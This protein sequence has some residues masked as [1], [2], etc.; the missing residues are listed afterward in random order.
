MFK[1]HTGQT[2]YDYLVETRIARA[3]KLLSSTS[4]KV[5]EVSELVGYM[6]KAH[7]TE[8]FKKKTGMTPK[9][10]QLKASQEKKRWYNK[11][12]ISKAFY[13]K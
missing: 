12:E 11:I 2:I 1:K 4:I 13:N 9:E 10:Y 5:Y 8:V 6:S 7:F 3:K